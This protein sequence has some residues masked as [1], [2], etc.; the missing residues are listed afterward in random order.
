MN[1]F[2]NV[3]TNGNLTTNGSPTTIN[4]NLSTPRTGTG[5]C[6]TNNVTAWTDNA[7]TVNGSIIE[8]P[9]PVTYPTPVIPHPERRTL[10]WGTTKRAQ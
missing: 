6:T 10:A 1:S 9:Q 8:L 5:T 4:G 3:G 7:G 2:G